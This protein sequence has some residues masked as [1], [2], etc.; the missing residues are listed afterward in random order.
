MIIKLEKGSVTEIGIFDIDDTIKLK[1][2]INN[3]VMIKVINIPPI[4]II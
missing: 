3:I 4:Y 1:D 2:E